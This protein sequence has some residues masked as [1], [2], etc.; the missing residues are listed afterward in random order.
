MD[1]VEGTAG[2]PRISDES[3]PGRTSRPSANPRQ[4][5]ADETCFTYKAVQ[6]F[7]L[8]KKLDAACDGSKKKRLIVKSVVLWFARFRFLL[9]YFVSPTNRNLKDM[10]RHNIA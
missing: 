7:A 1:G 2:G 9:I 8:A 3:S 4:P 5:H 6:K 10:Y